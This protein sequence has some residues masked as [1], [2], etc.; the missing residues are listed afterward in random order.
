LVLS[1][2]ANL[3]VDAKNPTLFL[4]DSKISLIAR[5]FSEPIVFLGL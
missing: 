1:V 4:P 5:V 2:Q 3:I